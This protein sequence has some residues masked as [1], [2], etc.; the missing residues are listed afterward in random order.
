MQSET[1]PAKLTP[2]LLTFTGI[3][4]LAIAAVFAITTLLNFEAPSAMGIVT[5]MVAVAPVMQ[6]F[7]KKEGRVPTKR[8]RVNFATGGTLLSII[9]SILAVIVA[10]LALDGAAAMND[11]V[12][13]GLSEL[14]AHPGLFA[15]IA[16]AVI[17]VS[18]LVI[19]FSSGFTARNSLKLLAKAK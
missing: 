9:C 14:S 18:W 19:Y 1:T 3:Y 11:L 13:L 10:V 17:V 15:A 16:A 8:E 12:T 4:L 5:L 2:Y 7:V 6:S